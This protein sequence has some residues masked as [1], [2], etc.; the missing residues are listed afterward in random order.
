MNLIIFRGNRTALLI[1]AKHAGARNESATDMGKHNLI[2]VNFIFGLLTFA[3]S[4]RDR[5]AMEH[6][7]ISEFRMGILR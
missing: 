2:Y 7:E 5:N 1:Q 3:E 6:Y 4:S